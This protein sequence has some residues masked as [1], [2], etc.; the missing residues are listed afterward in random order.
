MQWRQSVMGQAGFWNGWFGFS[1][2]EALLYVI[3]L[4]LI[5]MAVMVDW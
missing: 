3:F 5:A 4:L 2:D 1:R